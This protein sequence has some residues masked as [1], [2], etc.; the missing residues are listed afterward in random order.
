[1][2]EEIKYL[3]TRYGVLYEDL[4]DYTMTSNLIGVCLIRIQRRPEWHT[5]RIYLWI[6]NDVVYIS[7]VYRIE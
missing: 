4:V 3:G 6:C 1:M 7:M 2:A 5:L